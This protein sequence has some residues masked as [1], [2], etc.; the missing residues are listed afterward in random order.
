M[1]SE[2]FAWFGLM[3]APE[4]LERMRKLLPQ[5]LAED[6]AKEIQSAKSIPAESLLTRLH[7]L[8]DDQLAARRAAVPGVNRMPHPL[9]RH[10]LERAPE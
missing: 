4:R 8:R 2:A 1:N 7:D 5:S 3:A 6:V 10:M 9:L